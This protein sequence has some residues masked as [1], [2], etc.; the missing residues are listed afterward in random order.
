MFDKW[1]ARNRAQ[2]AAH[3]EAV[4]HA[5]RDGPVVRAGTIAASIAAS[6]DAA[7]KARLTPEVDRLR[8]RGT[9]A[10]TLAV[11]FGI[12]AASGMAIARYV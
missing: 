1:K 9:I 3:L 6:S 5:E 10:A 2:A 11:S 12:L 8:R 7:A 4:S